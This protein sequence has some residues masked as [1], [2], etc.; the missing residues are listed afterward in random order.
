MRLFL[1]GPAA[2]VIGGRMVGSGSDSPD[3]ITVDIGGTSSDIAL[4][5]SGKPMIRS[6]G[7]ICGYSVRVPMV[8]VNA[9]GAGGGS[10][11]WID[12]AGGLKV[13]PHSAGSD[14][15]PA[16]YGRG[17]EDA[18]V[19]DASVVLGYLDPDYFAGGTLKLH[20]EQA[21]RADEG[22]VAQPLGMTLE[23]AALG[24]HRVINAQMAEG[25]RL[26]SIRRGVDPRRFAL[27]PLGGAGPVHATALAEELGISRIILPRYPGVLSAMGL[28]DAPVE[29]EISAAFPRALAGLPF[30]D[31]RA[32][33]GELDNKCRSLMEQ[34][35]V[36]PVW[37]SVSYFADVSYV[38]Q[39]HHLEVPVRVDSPDPLGALLEDFK[40][41]HDQIYGHST[42]SPARI[43]N[44]RAVHQY[45]AKTTRGEIVAGD[46]DGAEKGKRS[47]LFPSPHGRMKTGIWDRNGLCPGARVVGPAIIEQADTTTVI[48]PDWRGE[49]NAR[50]DLAI[51]RVQVEEGGDM[52]GVTLH[53]DLDPITLEVV[54]NKLEGIANEM[55]TT[56]LRSSFSPIVKEG[57]DASASLFS[58]TGETLAQATAIPIHL[59]TLI[60]IVSKLIE[61]FP[62][63]A[64]K[65]GDVYILN[66]PYLGGTHL[67][68][69]AIVMP[70]F[71]DERPIAYSA[72]MT[73]H[74]DVGGM[75]PGSIPTDATEI[76]QEGLRIPPLKLRDGQCF[77]ETLISMLR[78]NVR[79]PDTVMGDLNAQV[80]ACNVGF[81]RLVE[82]AGT[83]GEDTLAAIFRE[84]LDRS[85]HLTRRALLSVPEG[86]YPYEDF[87]DNDGID[88]DQRIRIAVTVTIKNGRMTCDFT[89]SSPQVRGPFNCVPSGSHAA[90][91]FAVRAIT[92][93]DI[94]TNGGCFRP[95]DLMLPE[96]SIVNPEEPAP[97]CSRTATIKRVT[98]CILGALKNA[99]PDRVPADAAGELLVLAFGGRRDDGTRYVFGELIAGGSGA[100]NR[101]DGVDVIETDATNCMNLPVEALEMEAPVRI[102][103]FALRRDSGGEGMFRGGL[104]CVR[105]YEVLEGELTL[106][107]RG[108]R[109]FCAAQGAMGGGRGAVAVSRIQRAA[110]GEEVVPS[111]LVTRLVKGDRLVVETAGGGGYGSADQR[112]RE[113]VST[114]IEE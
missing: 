19:T 54:R 56:L 70:V 21:R 61:T 79:I 35:G 17:G 47:V 26:V 91:C 100:S 74:Q 20:P 99:L 15:G 44:L 67:P 76:F 59:A 113:H 5:T 71:H 98:G 64:M 89:R 41:A 48:A 80:A 97:V 11:A 87:L 90:A 33:L 13:G 37:V 88:L 53:T 81:R 63:E 12:G 110:G 72:T 103:R 40:A 1:S 22:R 36:D 49:V 32:A 23:E 38:G 6:E 85:A 60:P 84:L 51:T 42:D 77:N 31:V 105:E 75:A 29:H 27:V 50:G 102:H 86:V 3:I 7:L 9:I 96:G 43:V 106:T 83:Y 39:S 107:H 73:H 8:D 69:I 95:I 101:S 24:I 111:K 114:P 55:Q 10:V 94:P 30:T 78:Q 46:G 14:P 16:C 28:L 104:G 62:P 66:D 112:G 57:L 2:G 65:E 108:E 82:L 25:I 4:I 68:D 45:T 58:M 109:H 93:P 52:T 92:D 34:E 18:I